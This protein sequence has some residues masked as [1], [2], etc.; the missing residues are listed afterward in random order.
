MSAGHTRATGS[1]DRDTN[2]GT[3]KVLTGASFVGDVKFQG[4]DLF[5]EI[6]GQQAPDGRPKMSVFIEYLS[7]QVT[8]QVIQLPWQLHLDHCDAAHQLL[9]QAVVEWRTAIASNDIWVADG[10]KLAAI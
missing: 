10:F 2:R 4:L 9:C 1:F 7:Y 5:R 6:R 3:L 8:V